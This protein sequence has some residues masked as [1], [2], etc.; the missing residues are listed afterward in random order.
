PARSGPREPGAAAGA[1]RGWPRPGSRPPEA[2]AWPPTTRPAPGRPASAL[3]RRAPAAPVWPARRRRGR[4]AAP[5]C[6]RR[7]TGRRRGPAYRTCPA[8]RPASSTGTPRTAPPRRPA[9]AADRTPCA[10]PAPRAATTAQPRGNRSRGPGTARRTGRGTRPPAG[11]P[12]TPSAG[13][14]RRATAPGTPGSAQPTSGCPPARVAAS[15]ARRWPARTGTAEPTWPWPPHPR[16]SGSTSIP[17]VCAASNGPA[18]AAPDRARACAVGRTG[19]RSVPCRRRPRRRCRRNRAAIRRSCRSAPGREARRPGCR[20]RGE[21]PGTPPSW[22]L[23]SWVWPKGPPYDARRPRPRCLSSVLRWLPHM[24]GVVAGRLTATPGTSVRH[25][26]RHSG[27]AR[28]PSGGREPDGRVGRS[29]PLSTLS[30]VGRLVVIEGLDGAGKRT[31]TDALT[32]ALAEVGASVATLAFPRYGVS[33]HADLVREALHGAHGDLG[34]SVYGM[35]LLYAL[36][37]RGAA[38]EIRALRAGHD[39]LLLD[40]YVASNAAY[41]AARL[42]QGADS[43]VVRWVRDLEIERFGLPVPD[44]HLLL[45]VAPEVAADRKSTR[46]NSSHVKISYAVFCLKK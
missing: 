43:E 29:A 4:S 42:R 44:A 7:P 41:Q 6:R 27:T 8:V 5:P 25:C 28:R 17:R 36:D 20:G 19:G 23:W 40:R 11:R 35:G 38:D 14:P 26:G 24:G 45:R 18:P 34:D 30:T 10:A 33:V 16:S 13:W 9:A 1:A 37:R 39:V 12:A 3:A 21:A 31:L 2:R 46:L 15:S 32:A 22:G